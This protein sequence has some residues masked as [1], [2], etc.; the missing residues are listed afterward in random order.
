[1]E[2]S[3]QAPQLRTMQ[4]LAKEAYQV[5]N[6]CNLAGVIKGMDRAMMD[7]RRL[8]PSLGTSAYNTHPLMVMWADKIASLT[9]SQT[10]THAVMR[11][12]N[13]CGEQGAF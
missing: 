7:L 10:D 12:Y 2:A 11:A 9:G 3:Q 1:M 13:W 8:E 5:Q 4:D 6:A